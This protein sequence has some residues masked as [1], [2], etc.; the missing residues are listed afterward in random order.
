MEIIHPSGKSYELTKDA[1][2]EITSSNPF[3]NDMGEQS[4]PIKIPMT[5]RNKTILGFPDRTEIGRAN[6]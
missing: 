2:F 6:I 4:L 5:A 3:F 1:A